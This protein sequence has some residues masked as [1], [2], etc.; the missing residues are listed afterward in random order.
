[1]K[2]ILCILL[3]LSYIVLLILLFESDGRNISEGWRKAK[4]L[5]VLIAEAQGKKLCEYTVII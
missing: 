3:V 1:M 2:K 5:K 4:Y